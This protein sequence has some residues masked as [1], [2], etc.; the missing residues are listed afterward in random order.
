[1]G[2]AT[3]T[4]EPATLTRREGLQLS[5]VAVGAGALGAAGVSGC[6]PR[7]GQGA[8]G[9]Y[10]GALR[11]E[12]L[13]E[14]EDFLSRY[15]RRWTWDYTARST[16]FNNC[17]YQAHCAFEVYVRDGRVIREE[18]AATYTTKRR[19]LPDANPG[20]ARRAA[21]TANSCRGRRG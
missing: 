19:G 12:P 8:A 11:D 20:A 4:G 21:G 17:A 14:G 6:G 2:K 16:H 3:E 7:A 1:M 5:G 9:T 13:P 15:R 10:K 18:Q